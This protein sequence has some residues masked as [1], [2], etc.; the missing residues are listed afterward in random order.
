MEAHS[1][2]NARCS[3]CSEMFY[4]GLN[5]NYDIANMLDK[6]REEKAFEENMNGV[7]DYWENYDDEVDRA[8]W[9][10]KKNPKEAS[11]LAT[12]PP[13]QES[14]VSRGGGLVIQRDVGTS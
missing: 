2:C 12:F 6:F 14:G 4:G 9:W 10:I 5:P 3:Y 11:V 7:Y 1:N 13:S 8:S